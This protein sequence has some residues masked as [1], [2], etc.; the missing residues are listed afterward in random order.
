LGDSISTG[1]VSWVRASERR[2]VEEKLGLAFWG[3]V[4]PDA[5]TFFDPTIWFGSELF[6]SDS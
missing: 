6:H 5:A 3:T 1:A 4:D 2:F